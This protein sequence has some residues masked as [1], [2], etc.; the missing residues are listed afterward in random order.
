[1][2]WQCKSTTDGAHSDMILCWPFYLPNEFNKIVLF[3]VY[4]PPDSN[5]DMAAEILENSIVNIE[6]VSLE[7]VKIIPG[8]FNH[9]NFNDRIPTYEQFVNC[10]TRGDVTLDKLYCN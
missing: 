5:E 9:C 1:M 6:N 8:D 10:T 3:I 7:S 2:G 4:I